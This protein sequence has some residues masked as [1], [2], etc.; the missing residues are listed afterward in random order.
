M[1]DKTHKKVHDK[2]HNKMHGKMHEGNVRVKRIMITILAF[3][4]MLTAGC[5]QATQP[6]MT[7]QS[8]VK[9]ATVSGYVTNANGSALIS[10]IVLSN[11]D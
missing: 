4:C 2:T 1:H 8:V 10:Q 11:E 3:G 6:E 5:T 7:T 9:Q